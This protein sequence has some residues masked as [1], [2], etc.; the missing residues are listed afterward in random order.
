MQFLLINSEWYNE[1]PDYDK[2]NQM[3]QNTFCHTYCN[4]INVKILT[5]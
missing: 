4:C 3:L 2:L 5:L 1:D